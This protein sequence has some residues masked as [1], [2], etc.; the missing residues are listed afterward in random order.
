MLHRAFS[1]ANGNHPETIPVR[2][3]IK[4][5]D[6]TSVARHGR[7]RQTWGYDG[8]FK[9]EKDG[10]GVFPDDDGCVAGVVSAGKVEFE[11][12]TLRHGEEGCCL[13]YLGRWASYTGQRN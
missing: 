3:P 6:G 9:L 13:I 8:G 5:S 4:R 11:L 10:C 2:V 7:A 12:E 1:I